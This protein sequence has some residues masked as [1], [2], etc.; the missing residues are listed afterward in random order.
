MTRCAGE[1]SRLSSSVHSF[2]VCL[3]PVAAG[4]LVTDWTPDEDLFGLCFVSADRP[5]G[6]YTLSSS[7]VRCHS[8]SCWIIL[9]D[10]RTC[11]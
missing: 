2:P 7:V 8:G 6:H 4:S 10:P 9:P 11:S 3:S 1:A 5:R